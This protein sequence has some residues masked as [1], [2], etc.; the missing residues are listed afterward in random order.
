MEPIDVEGNEY[1]VW[2]NH[3]NLLRLDVTTPKIAWLRVIKTGTQ[4]SAQEFAGLRERAK[5][6]VEPEP[7]LRAIRRKLG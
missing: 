1:D 7:L 5:V 4:V 6:Y 2:D 3:G